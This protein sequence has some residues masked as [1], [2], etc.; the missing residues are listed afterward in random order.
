MWILLIIAIDIG[1]LNLI[2]HN[3]DAGAIQE[4]IDG[5]MVWWYDGMMVE[6]KEF[7]GYNP[8]SMAVYTCALQTKNYSQKYKKNN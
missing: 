7:S 8:V 3:S 4:R 1:S 5:M 6:L 2:S